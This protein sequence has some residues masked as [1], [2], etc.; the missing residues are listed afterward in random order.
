MKYWIIRMPEPSPFGDT[1][2]RAIVRAISLAN[3]VNVPGGG[4]VESVATFLTHR[5]PVR[6]AP[7]VCLSRQ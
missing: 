1:S 4:A 2:L 6:F 3:F 5:R 7:T